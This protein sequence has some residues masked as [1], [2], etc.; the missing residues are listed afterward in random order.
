MKIGYAVL[1]FV[2]SIISFLSLSLFS[3]KERILMSCREWRRFVLALWFRRSTRDSFPRR[4]SV[5]VV[6]GADRVV[7]N[8]QRGRCPAWS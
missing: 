4:E 7:L 8:A 6:R 5:S 3:S 1:L 2:S